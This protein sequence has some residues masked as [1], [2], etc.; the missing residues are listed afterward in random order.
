MKLWRNWTLLHCCWECKIVPLLQKTVWGTLKKLRIDL[1]YYVAIS[2]LDI[3]WKQG[4]AGTERDIRTPTFITTWLAVAKT[5]KQHKCPLMDTWISKT[6]AVCIGLQV[7]YSALKRKE[8]LTSAP[9]WINF[10]EIRLSEVSQS[11]AKGQ[12]HNEYL[13]AC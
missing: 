4:K 1:S 11:V 12:I 8:M 3:Y 10:E 13:C 7:R 5:W 9:T 6:W 2:L